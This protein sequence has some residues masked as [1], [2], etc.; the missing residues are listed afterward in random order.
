MAVTL[1]VYCNC[2][3][4]GVWCLAQ[5]HHS[6]NCKWRVARAKLC[7]FTFH[8][9][10]LISSHRLAF[11]PSGLPGIMTHHLFTERNHVI[12]SYSIKSMYSHRISSVWTSSLTQWWWTSHL[13]SCECLLNLSAY[14]ARLDTDSS[15]GADAVEWKPCQDQ[16]SHIVSPFFWSLS[17][18]SKSPPARQLLPCH[19]SMADIRSAQRG[20]RW[21]VVTVDLSTSAWLNWLDRSEFGLDCFLYSGSVCAQRARTC[22]DTWS[23]LKEESPWKSSANLTWHGETRCIFPQLRS[24]IWFLVSVFTTCFFFL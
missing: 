13:F 18:L 15:D 9:S 10:Q 4:R 23:H 20:S 3:I 1:S 5:G 2:N 12:L 11:L 21:S 8:S 6:N 7:P 24:H 16:R 19:L 22:T 14:W 17:V